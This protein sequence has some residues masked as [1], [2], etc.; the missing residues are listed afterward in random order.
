MPRESPA[1]L[2]NGSSEVSLARR[3]SPAIL[4]SDHRHMWKEERRAM[5]DTE[6]MRLE[7]WVKLPAD[8]QTR[9]VQALNPYAGE[10]ASLIKRVCEAFAAEYGD[11]DGI[12]EVNFA[13]YHGGEY[14][15]T[16]VT[17]V[18]SSPHLPDRYLGV[19]VVQLYT[20]VGRVLGAKLGG[21]YDEL[22]EGIDRYYESVVAELE[23]LGLTLETASKD[24]I[25]QAVEA[26]KR[27]WSQGQAM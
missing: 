25:R 20:H 11:Q 4:S 5:T 22:A 24:Q 12:A 18:P 16:V 17:V 23:R 10:G 3:T 14:V 13:T 8:E 1:V 15:I 7:E 27:Q 9:I 6:R 21:D 2:H 19:R 26:A